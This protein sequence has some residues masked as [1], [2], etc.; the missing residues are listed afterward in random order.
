[1]GAAEVRAMLDR[2]PGSERGR[3]VAAARE[4]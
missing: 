1:V 3:E 2:F 4:A